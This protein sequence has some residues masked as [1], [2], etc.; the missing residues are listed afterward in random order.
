MP[1]TRVSALWCICLLGL[2][3]VAQP[4]TSFAQSAPVQIN[5]SETVGVSSGS[6]NQPAQTVLAAEP[7]HIADS[8]VTAPALAINVSEMLDVMTA[9]TV[10]PAIQLNLAEDV[11]V[12]SASS[13]RAAISISVKEGVVTGDA[14]QTLGGTG[15]P[16]A[17]NDSYQT[18]EDTA[19]T[20]PGPG[21]LA[22]DNGQNLQATLVTST[23]HGTLNLAGDGSF[24]YTPDPG[25]TATDSFAYLAKSGFVVSNVATVTIS[26]QSMPS[27][28]G[29]S[30]GPPNPG[31]TPE[32]D[33]LLL[34]ATGLSGFGCAAWFRRVRSRKKRSRL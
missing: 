3:V 34:F 14:I 20:I 4:P 10:Q 15:A 6:S 21:V 27:G 17:N 31:A 16:I 5:V 33:S 22:N 26:V 28:G 32:L 25:F 9:G 7:I 11:V 8:V 12:A 2:A 24:T 19:L 13:S 1:S 23:T 18:F 30:G 29:G